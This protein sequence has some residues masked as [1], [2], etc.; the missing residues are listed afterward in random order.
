M[1][2]NAVA[3]VLQLCPRSDRVSLDT[4]RD[5][6]PMRIAAD[7][8]PPAAENLMDERQRKPAL[9]GPFGDVGPGRNELFAGREGAH[10]QVVVN[11]GDSVRHV[12]CISLLKLVLI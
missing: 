11:I 6:D 10:A 8:P 12:S 1:P 2:I 7:A 9:T 4:Q 3:G 5:G